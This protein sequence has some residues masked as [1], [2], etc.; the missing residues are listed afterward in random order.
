MEPFFQRLASGLQAAVVVSLLGSAVLARADE[1]GRPVE[2]CQSRQTA[3]WG[4]CRADGSN[5]PPVVGQTFD[6][7]GAGT[8]LFPARKAEG[9]PMGYIDASGLW[10]IPPRFLRAE[11]FSEGVAVVSDGPRSAAIAADGKIAIPWFDGLLY[12][13]NQGLACFVPQGKIE[14]TFWGRARHKLLGGPGDDPYPAAWWHIQ[15]KVGF[16]D[17]AGR[18]VIEPRFEPKL[19]FLVGGCGFGSAGYAAM[20]ENGK[21]GLIDRSG[22]W[23]VQPEYDYLALVFSGN[24]K[25]VAMIADRTLAHG[26]FLDTVERF[27]GFMGPDGAVRWRETGPPHEAT[28]A[29][30]LVREFANWAL[31]PRWQEDLTKEEVSSGTLVAWTGS[32]VL[33]CAALA[34]A[35]G[36]L[37]RRT[38]RHLAVRWF[39]ALLAGAA[40]VATTFI[41]GLLSAYITVALLMAVAVMA[42]RAWTLSRSPR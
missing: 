40:T 6:F 33:G 25:V 11:A 21:E 5:A 35:A 38:R 20:R 3:L 37:R 30:G 8:E 31:F 17:A 41:G 23:I 39:V 27:D 19:N 12:P 36:L 34:F 26:V 2:P 10:R 7:I 28:I 32:I 13:V 24:R 29:G 42:F 16:M 15:G 4:L 22:R 9:A 14:P 1:P 18:T